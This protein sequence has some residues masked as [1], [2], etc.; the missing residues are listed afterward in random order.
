MPITTNTTSAAAAT[1]VAGVGGQM[2]STI[3]P[4]ISDLGMGP[5]YRLSSENVRLSPIT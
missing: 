1:Q 2:T 4:T 3:S 5:K